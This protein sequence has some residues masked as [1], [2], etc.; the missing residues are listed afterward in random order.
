M[1]VGFGSASWWWQVRPVKSVLSRLG[2]STPRVLSRDRQ[3]RTVPR[4]FYTGD[5]MPLRKPTS[6]VGPCMAIYFVGKECLRGFFGHPTL[7]C[8][9]ELTTEIIAFEN[10]S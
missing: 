10:E 6:G 3:E 5:L 7:V 4:S 9:V 8:L 1:F 2:R